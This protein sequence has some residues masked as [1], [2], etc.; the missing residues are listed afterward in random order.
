M[1]GIIGTRGDVKRYHGD[2]SLSLQNDKIVLCQLLVTRV[3][4]LIPNFNL[5]SRFKI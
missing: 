4:I 1:M 3:K 5:C 2:Y